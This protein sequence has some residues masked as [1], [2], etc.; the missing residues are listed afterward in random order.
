MK[1]AFNLFIALLVSFTIVSCDDSVVYKAFEDIPDGMWYLKN[2]PQFKV[3]IKD[4]N[5]TYNVYYV[6]RNA[7]QYPY[8]NLYLTREINTPDGAKS[9]VMQEIF[10]SNE[11]TGKP[12]GN[13][14]G[15][16]FDHKILALK[17]HKFERSGLYTFTL[18]QAMRQNPL[19]FVLSV[20]ISVEKIK[21]T[22]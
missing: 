13:G 3:D 17:N 7:S 22:P 20:G 4:T 18:S 21:T 16:L 12:Y 6:I 8:Y 5:Q 9:N 11:V 15:D 1:S 14:L 2:K 10:L 19:P